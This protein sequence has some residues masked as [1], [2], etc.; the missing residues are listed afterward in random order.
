MAK[1]WGQLGRENGNMFSFRMR[2]AGDGA[3][4]YEAPFFL[5]LW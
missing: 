5:Y 3:E 4:V 1:A 2:R